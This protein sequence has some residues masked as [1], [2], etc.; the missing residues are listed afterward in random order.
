[1]IENFGAFALLKLAIF[2]L[3]QEVSCGEHGGS[4]REGGKASSGAM[5]I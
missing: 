5:G 3:H 4:D 1:L 2:R